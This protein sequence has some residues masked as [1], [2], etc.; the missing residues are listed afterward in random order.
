[1]TKKNDLPPVGAAVV[2]VVAL[3]ILPVHSSE[4]WKCRQKF[5]GK[6]V[7]KPQFVRTL[8]AAGP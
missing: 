8:T 4:L 6:S 1:M 3:S 5:H 7:S 2:V